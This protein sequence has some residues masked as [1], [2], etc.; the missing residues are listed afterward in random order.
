MPAGTI[1]AVSIL[2]VDIETL[3][4]RGR[5]MTYEEAVA[6]VER[7]MTLVLT[8]LQ[9]TRESLSVIGACE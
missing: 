2:D 7:V 8:V 5:S 4:E 9:R 6:E 1:P 3:R